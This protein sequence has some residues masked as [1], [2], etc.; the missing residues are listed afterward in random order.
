[1]EMTCPQCGRVLHYLGEP[2]TFCGY[3]GKPLAAPPEP[4]VA[5]TPGADTAPEGGKDGSAPEVVGGYQLLRPLGAGGMG[6][7]YEAEEAASRQRVALKLIAPEHAASPEAVERFRQEGRLASAIAHPRCVFVLAADEDA[8]R[9]YIVMEL[10][11][12][13]TLKDLVDRRG[14]LPPEEAVLRILDVIEGLQEAHALGVVHRDVKPSNCFV[15]VDGRVKIG[16]FGLSKSLVSST[17]LT[18]T[19]SFLGTPLYASPEQIRCEVVDQQTDVYSVA[20]TLYYLL[21]GR[22]PFEGGDAAATMARIVADPPPRIRGQRPDV[23]R[24]LERVILRGLERQRERRWRSLAEMRA[25]LLPVVPGRLSIGGMGVRVGAYLIDYLVLGI[26]T[27]I[28]NL[29][30]LRLLGPASAAGLP[31]LLASLAVWVAYFTL[32]EGRWG[33]SLGKR[34]LRLRVC[35]KTGSQP[36]G[37]VLAFPRILCFYLLDHLGTLWIFLV[38][39]FGGLEADPATLG[40]AILLFYPLQVLGIGLMMCTMRA[41]NGYRGLH[42]WLSGTRVVSLPGRERRLRAPLRPRLEAKPLAGLPERLGP[43]AV[44]GV[45]RAQDAEKVLLGEDTVLGRRAFLW[46]RL[47]GAGSLTPERLAVKRRTRPRW[48]TGG[49]EGEVSWDAF[50]AARGCSLT[51]FC[52]AAGPLPWA[53]A[54]PLLEQLTDELSAASD[55]GTLPRE[56]TLAHLWVQAEGRVQLLDTPL[57][58]DPPADSTLP[59]QTGDEQRALELVRQTAVLLLE[60]RLRSAGERMPGV[61]APLPGHARELMARLLGG[62]PACAG[63][64]QLQQELAATAD[65]PV[66]VTRA[67]RCGHLLL[68][69]A[70]LV[71]GLF[72]TMLTAPSW[73][74]AVVIRDE[75]VAVQA[76]EKAQRTLA[77]ASARDLAAA[78]LSPSPPVLLLAAE[79]FGQDH[80][81]WSR[82]RKRG[83][84]AAAAYGADLSA[85]GTLTRSLAL[86][87]APAAL[88]KSPG[89]ASDP[90][91]AARALL[92]QPEVPSPPDEEREP[93]PLIMVVTW[94]LLWI[95]WAFL[96]R[97]GLS[98]RIL[99]MSLVRR[100]GRKAARWQCAWRAF[101]VWAPV[102]VLLGA[103]AQL[104]I[105]YWWGHRGEPVRDADL[106]T[107]STALW[108]LAVGLLALYAI[109]AVWRPQRSLHDRLAGTYLVP[110]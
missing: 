68:L 104:E 24:A 65:R 50:F 93:F 82:L 97:G 15:D 20:A 81:L 53:D 71:G 94:P 59:T 55:D 27:T 3:C 77:A 40:L 79:R 90:R 16:D 72:T 108:W 106:L 85:T 30:V 78:I 58:D 11:P 84:R 67:R 73:P 51:E 43:F 57:T 25:A 102:T 75:F 66:E 23:P 80:A 105:L 26:L 60:G 88:S 70:L 91:K 98:F 95:L 31:S 46:L 8:G 1:M 44:R 89:G 56:I 45:L 107:L 47:A 36:P 5:F 103:S 14:P 4:T 87:A 76:A 83:A 54:R 109:L 9:P 62:E 35:R 42:E 52:R 64:R 48:L 86:L 63:V 110:R 74:S 61:R 38:L 92:E 99:G 49:K 19:G 28:V 101:V 39:R 37:V 12:G 69:S 2:P 6:K 7:V 13:S 17:Q 22:A 100:D 29:G 18:R 32:L 41:R 34:L 96:L 21:T 33:C 10:M